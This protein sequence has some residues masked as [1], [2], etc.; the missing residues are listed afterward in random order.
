MNV[1]RVGPILLAALAACVQTSCIQPAQERYREE[2]SAAPPPLR[3]AVTDARLRAVMADLSDLRA[4]RLPREFDPEPG[5]ALRREEIAALAAALAE[6]AAR[7]PDAIPAERL[8]AGEEGAFLGL[9]GRLAEETRALAE[10]APRLPV[11]GLRE[12]VDRIGAICD[13]CHTRFRIAP[14]PAAP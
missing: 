5:R 11:Q 6:A 13:A 10:E 8:P 3:H 12:R 9:A 1:R 7:I 2:L 4:E 14:E